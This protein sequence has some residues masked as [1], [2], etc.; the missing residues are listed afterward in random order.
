M[1]RLS[2]CEGVGKERVW[3]VCRERLSHLGQYVGDVRLV[4]RREGKGKHE[5]MT[6]VINSSAS[7][8]NQKHIFDALP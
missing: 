3:G 5:M 6:E 8:R 1:N 2:I 7:I 4:E